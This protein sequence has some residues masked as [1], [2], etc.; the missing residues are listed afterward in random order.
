[1]PDSDDEPL[2]PGPIVPLNPA[3]PL[4][5]E[6]VTPLVEDSDDDDRPLFPPDSD[7]EPLFPWP[8]QGIIIGG[9]F[10]VPT[11]LILAPHIP[12][13][14]FVAPPVPPVPALVY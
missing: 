8:M 2:F 3:L 4:P 11:E 6:P 12:L 5:P 14:T 7:D 13:P 1:M 10:L 9:V